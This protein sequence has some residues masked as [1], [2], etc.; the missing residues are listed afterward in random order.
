MKAQHTWH[1]DHALYFF[2]GGMGAA[3]YIIGVIASFIGGAWEPLA[4]IGIW[5]GFPLIVI[6]AIVLLLGLGN[7]LHAIHAWKCPNTSWISR[8]VIIVSVFTG[9]SFLHLLFL[10]VP[11]LASMTG[12]ANF[13]GI[14]GFIFAFGVI[15]YTAFL[16]A[17][18]RPVALWSNSLLPFTFLAS[19]MYSGFLLVMLI[20]TLKGGPAMATPLKCLAGTTILLALVI[21]FVVITMIQGSHR[22]PEARDSAQII[23]KGNLSMMFWWG[24]IIIGLLVPIA[25]EVVNFALTGGVG[26]SLNFIAAIAGLIG[27]IC[28]R[29][30]IL[31]GGVFAQLKAGRFEYQLPH[32]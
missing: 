12:A 25:A 20:A 8:G 19:A 14:I 27:C 11:S 29:Q 21:L 7:P 30:V 10:N 28:L 24:V 5:T 1:F 13:L 6:A 2:L 16:L 17:A 15:L 22:T 4:S 26:A 9:V 18:N 23:L 32:I 3:G 31:A